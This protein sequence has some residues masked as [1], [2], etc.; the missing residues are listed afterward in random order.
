[1][2]MTEVPPDDIGWI[3][4]WAVRKAILVRRTAKNVTS[5]IE[6]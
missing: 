6:A 5:G 4:G 1:M 3:P 2:L